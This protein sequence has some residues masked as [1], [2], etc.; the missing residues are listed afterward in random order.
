MSNINTSTEMKAKTTMPT[1]RLVV[2]SDKF[3]YVSS[4]ATDIRKTFDNARKGKKNAQ[5]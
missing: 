2:P 3:V 4:A 1:R 5:R